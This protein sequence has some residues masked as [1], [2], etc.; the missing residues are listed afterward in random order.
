MKRRFAAEPY[1]EKCHNFQSCFRRMDLFIDRGR[2]K[3][4]REE[5]I[6]IKILLGFL[7]LITFNVMYIDFTTLTTTEIQEI[8][9][10]SR[11][12]MVMKKEKRNEAITLSLI[13]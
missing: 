7:S 13:H 5:I 9:M 1:N 10:N 3:T 2:M 11:H 4:L 12:F 6:E 8:T